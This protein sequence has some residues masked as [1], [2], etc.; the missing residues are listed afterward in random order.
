MKARSRVETAREHVD[1]MA[2]F[3]VRRREVNGLLGG[4]CMWQ[5]TVGMGGR[6]KAGGKNTL[7]EQRTTRENDCEGSHVTPK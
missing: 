1:A 7:F 3:A 6:R 2:M 4:V 5:A